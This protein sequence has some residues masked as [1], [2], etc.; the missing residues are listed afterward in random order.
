LGAVQCETLI[1]CGKKPARLAIPRL[2]RLLDDETSSLS[3]A[4]YR[5]SASPAAFT[6]NHPSSIQV[7]M[8]DKT[9]PDH[10]PSNQCNHPSS[11]SGRSLGMNGSLNFQGS[12]TTLMT[13]L[14][15]ESI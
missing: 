14:N 7:Q 5:L 3:A 6:F 4:D 10:Y 1:E 12:P 11:F 13:G 8:A 9:S 2:A 15:W